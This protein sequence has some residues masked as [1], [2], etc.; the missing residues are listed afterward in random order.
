MTETAFQRFQHY[1]GLMLG[2]RLHADQA[3]LQK[4]H[5]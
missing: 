3:W 2:V 4:F 1:P 5:Y